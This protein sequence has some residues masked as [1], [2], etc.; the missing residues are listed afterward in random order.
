MVSPESMGIGSHKARGA[1]P[2][3]DSAPL[4]VWAFALLALASGTLGAAD[5]RCANEIVDV[6]HSPNGRFKAVVFVRA[7]SDPARFSTQVSVLKSERPLSNVA[8]NVFMCDGSYGLSPS[9]SGRCRVAAAWNANDQLVV[10]YPSE[11]EVLAAKQRFK[12]IQIGYEP[13]EGTCN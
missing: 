8:G 6:T 13:A 10:R 1:N 7:C 2:W 3:S 9:S 4:A 12:G 5:T 11:A